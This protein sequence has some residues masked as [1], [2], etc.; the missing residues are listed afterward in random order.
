[1]FFV[2]N[3]MFSPK[4]CKAYGTW[5]YCYMY[6]QLLTV[7]KVCLN[8][9]YSA[10][11]LCMSNIY[12]LYEILRGLVPD[13]IIQLLILIYVIIT[14]HLN[15]EY[16]VWES[17]A[18]YMKCYTSSFSNITMVVGKSIE[19]TT[20]VFHM[21]I[22]LWNVFI[23]MLLNLRRG[24]PVALYML[25]YW[26]V[27]LTNRLRWW[28]TGDDMTWGNGILHSRHASSCLLFSSSPR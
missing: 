11:D 13:H 28:L 21:Y 19:P 26:H 9:E 5:P 14:V 15:V 6:I 12:I 27:G 1:M 7:M 3:T 25:D 17:S 10:W 4:I 16:G 8:I 23:Q 24:V 20:T 18:E 22:L 2:E